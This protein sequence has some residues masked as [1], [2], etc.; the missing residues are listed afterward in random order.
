LLFHD[1]LIAAF[2]NLPN[3]IALCREYALWI[4]VFPL[5]IGIGLVYY[6]VFTGATYTA[7]IRNSMLI[8]LLVFIIV[9]FSMIS[10]YKN[11]GL[12]L[13]FILFSLGRSLVLF[14][15]RKKLIAENF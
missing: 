3:V 2:T 7:P 13:A 14:L 15:G 11:H 1:G 4:A 12:W 8:A 6:G 9:Y 5:V 10:R